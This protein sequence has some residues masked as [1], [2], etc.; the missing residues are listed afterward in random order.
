MDY[1]GIILLI[2][3]GTGLICCTLSLIYVIR[4]ISNKKTKII[5]RVADICIITV[6]TLQIITHYFINFI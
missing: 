5:N 4:G 6:I 3:L 2:L 1:V